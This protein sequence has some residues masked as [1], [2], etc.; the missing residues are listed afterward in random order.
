VTVPVVKPQQRRWLSQ[1]RERFGN[2][3]VIEWR[4]FLDR[5]DRYCP[6]LDLAVG[7]FSTVRGQRKVGQYR[8]LARAHRTF[9][10]ELWTCHL[11]NEARLGFR[12]DQCTADLDEALLA[13]HN[14]R[15]F[16]AIEI[17]NVVSRKHLMGGVINAAALGHIGIVIGWTEDK[18]KAVFRA[19]RYLHFLKRVDKP[20]IAVGNLLVLSR[21]QARDLFRVAR[22]LPN[23]RFRLIG[24]GDRRVNPSSARSRPR[25]PR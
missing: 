1:L 6:H 9:L 11:Q 13:N 8:S 17:E 23:T 5:Q 14:G 20:A 3:C 12:D 21:D 4:A 24:R 18:V 15:C 7:P 16:L 2:E 10:N 22:A 25:A 19:R